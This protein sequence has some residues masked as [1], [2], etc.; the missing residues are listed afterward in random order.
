MTSI[1][2]ENRSRCTAKSKRSKERCQ[3]TPVP[4][5]NVCRMH[6]A[7]G[8]RPIKHGRYSKVLGRL[9]KSYEEALAHESLLDLGPTLALLDVRAE[10]LLEQ[11]EAGRD[12]AWQELV[13]VI[14]QRARRTEK[15][16]EL[17]LKGQQAI[18]ARDLVGV[19]TRFANLIIDEIGPAAAKPVIDRLDREILGDL[20][21]RSS[22]NAN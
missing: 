8:G 2:N 18:N 1:S 19:L 9:R 13:E 3:N 15:A 11:V 17:R 4:G 22:R 14:G 10:Q 7:G 16:C 12:G 5:W 6:G 20:E 21:G